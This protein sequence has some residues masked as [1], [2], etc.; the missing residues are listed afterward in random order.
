MQPLDAKKYAL[1]MHTPPS[2]G[3]Y[4]LHG[5]PATTTQESRG[6]RQFIDSP[7]KSDRYN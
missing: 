3:A 7:L 1:R 2:R 4:A 6:P 5:G